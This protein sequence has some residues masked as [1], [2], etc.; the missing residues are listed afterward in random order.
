MATPKDL[1]GSS[2]CGF[3]FLL[4]YGAGHSDGNVQHPIARGGQRRLGGPQSAPHGGISLQPITHLF[5]VSPIMFLFYKRMF[6]RMCQQPGII[7]S[8]QVQN[9]MSSV[10]VQRSVSSLSNTV[11]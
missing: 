9:F 6:P 5:L 11:R 8:L 1:L 3:S 4:L 2:F 10:S 7:G